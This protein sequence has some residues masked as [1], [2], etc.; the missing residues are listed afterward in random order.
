MTIYEDMLAALDRIEIPPYRELRCGPVAAAVL[1][2]GMRADPL[3][4]ADPLWGIPI[5]V[6]PEMR[7]A[8]WQLLADGEVLHE[9][10]MVP[11]HPRAFCLGG[12]LFGVSEEV[13][14]MI[15]DNVKRSRGGPPS[16]AVITD[17]DAWRI[18]IGREEA[19]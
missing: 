3:G 9:G 15:D 19:P 5:R 17:E 14:A 7:D 13:A 2:S 18:Q 1:R 10:D 12:M 4:R 8:A 6:D 11:D 16:L